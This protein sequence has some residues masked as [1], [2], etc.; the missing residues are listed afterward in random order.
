MSEMDKGLG[1]SLPVMVGNVGDEAEVDQGESAAG[2]TRW[3]GQQ[4]ARVRV[5][6]K[7]LKK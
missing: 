3:K 6:S 4:V 1:N 2:V 5:L 7:V